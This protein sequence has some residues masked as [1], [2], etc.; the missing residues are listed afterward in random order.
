VARAG[1]AAQ[2]ASDGADRL[3][4]WCALAGL[5][6]RP[7]LAPEPV[8]GPAT[9]IELIARPRRAPRA[10]ASLSLA[11]EK[12]P[13]LFPYHAFYPAAWPVGPGAQGFTWPVLCRG[14][15]ISD[16]RLTVHIDRTGP[17]AVE[18]VSVAAYR[19]QNGQILSSAPL[20]HFGQ[21]LPAEVA[22][23]E[24]DIVC[25]IAP[26]QLPAPAGGADV[27]AA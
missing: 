27:V 20:A 23:A 5:G 13:D 15:G 14:G 11:Y 12:L 9:R 21:T 16:L 17:W 1:E 7:V 6:R 25:E 24:S 26:F 19:Y 8:R 2:F 10:A 18:R 4:A 3:A 22:A